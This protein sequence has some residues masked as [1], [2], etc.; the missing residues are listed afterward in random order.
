MRRTAE[1][2]YLAAAELVARVAGRAGPFRTVFLPLRSEL[3][4]EE[5]PAR[6]FSRGGGEY[7]G[8]LAALRWARED[9]ELRGVLVYLDGVDL[10]WARAEELRRVLVALREHGKR[11][12]VHWHRGKLVDYLVATAAERILLPPSATLELTGLAAEVV[13]LR[14]L[15]DKL[16]VAAELVQVGEFKSAAEPFTRRE[17]SAEHRQM[18]EELVGDLYQQVCAE[19]ERA[20]PFLRGKAED[21]LGRGP[22]L[23]HEALER[24]LVDAVMYRDEALREFEAECGGPVVPFRRYARHRNR[25][26]RRRALR[27][28]HGAIGLVEVS[29]PLT[30]GES[31]PGP[32]GWAT[33]G[34]AT[35]EKE[36]DRL[37]D[38]PDVR[39]L[40]LRVSSPGGSGF[41]SDLLWRS[42]VRVREKKPVVVSLGE[43]AA[44]GAYY[45]ACAGNPLYAEKATLTG[46]I[47]VLAGKANFRGLY[48][49]VGVAKE[50]VSRGEHAR[51]YSDYTPLAQ[52]ERERLEAHARSFYVRF[53]EKVA[54]ARGLSIEDAERAARGRVWTGRQALGRKLVDALGGLLEALEEAK[55]RAGIPPSEPVPILGVPRRPLWRLAR[56]G[57]PWRTGFSGARNSVERDLVWAVLPF[58]IRFF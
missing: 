43:T 47:G 33:A 2:A 23:A 18:L 37:G 27:S 36:L 4:E 9:E 20:R 51:F 42:V 50:A 48:D 41:A 30:S 15:L 57:R 31:Q 8:L 39:A 6:L 29:G 46:S 38:R 26:L 49:R 35:L 17:M 53:L 10:G 1:R 13:F 14:D 25:A 12:W 55:R 32:G 3:G 44:S 19:V 7:L 58:E 21:V 28:A 40:V 45:V 11:V 34:A 54:E 16:G 52:S 24:R 5:R 22:Y 56:L